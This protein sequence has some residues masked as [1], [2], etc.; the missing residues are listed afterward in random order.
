MRIKVTVGTPQEIYSYG[1]HLLEASFALRQSSKVPLDPSE[2]YGAKLKNCWKK[3]QDV[4]LE[5][6]TRLRVSAVFHRSVDDY[7][8]KLQDLR[9]VVCD[10]D[11]QEEVLKRQM[12]HRERLLVEVGRT[13]RLGRLLKTRLKEPLLVVE[14]GAEATDE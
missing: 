2:E 3:L 13:V 14:Q 10:S 9:S 11:I 4:S 7:C 5:Q 1:C 8:T 6:L 12:S